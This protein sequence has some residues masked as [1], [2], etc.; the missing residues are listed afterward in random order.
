MSQPDNDPPTLEEQVALSKQQLAQAQK[1]T[2]L[3]EL[4]STT[5]HEF[6]NVLM[7]IINYAKMGMRHKD[8]P[9]RDKALE[10][11]LAAANG[12]PKS[13]TASWASPATARNARADRSGKVDRRFAGAAGARDEQVSHPRRDALRNQCRRRWPTA[14]RFSKC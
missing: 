14:T 12:P 5:T 4:V 7:T 10:K 1:L 8:T 6:N 13:P 11:I 2:A 9:T 3:G